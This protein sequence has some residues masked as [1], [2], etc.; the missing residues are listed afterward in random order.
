[1]PTE[2]LTSPATP[3]P[4]PTPAPAAPSAAFSTHAAAP[5][6]YKL[7]TLSVQDMKS[8]EEKLQKAIARQS[9]FDLFLIFPSYIWW[10][11]SFWSY[12]KLIYSQVLFMKWIASIITG[13]ACF[14][15]TNL[16]LMQ[17]LMLKDNL[18]T[19]QEDLLAEIEDLTR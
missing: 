14:V 11:L 10:K 13:F 4:V 2:E 16:D 15:E 12:L 9:H 19:Q 8:I 1:M 5:V 18:R 17:A 6:K 7:R 3:V